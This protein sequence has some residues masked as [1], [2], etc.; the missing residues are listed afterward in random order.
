M[1]K[2]F[3]SGSLLNRIDQLLKWELSRVTKC[4]CNDGFIK[5][6]MLKMLWGTVCT[7]QVTWVTCTVCRT[8]SPCQHIGQFPTWLGCVFTAAC[9]TLE[10][11]H[12]QSAS[13]SYK[14][15]RVLWVCVWDIWKWEFD[16]SQWRHVQLWCATDTTV[17]RWRWGTRNKWL[18]ENN[19]T[20]TVH[21][22]FFSCYSWF[23]LMHMYPLSHM[24]TQHKTCTYV[25]MCT[26]HQSNMDLPYC[27]SDTAD[28]Y[29]ERWL[30]VCCVLYIIC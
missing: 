28:T 26:Q 30:V 10:H 18:P 23:V 25:H 22:V 13:C 9:F 12:Q 2:S 14:W 7:V 15:L 4:V 1:D 6:T 29:L 5:I 21:E 19:N 8:S 3:A 11:H 16:C 24:H 27:T 17:S 20:H